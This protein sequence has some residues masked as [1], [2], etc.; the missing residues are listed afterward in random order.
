MSLIRTLQLFFESFHSFLNFPLV[1][2]DI[3]VFLQIS[4]HKNRIIDIRS[5]LPIAAMKQ[6]CL[7]CDSIT[8]SGIA[9]KTKKNCLNSNGEISNT[10]L[11]KP[12]NWH[13]KGKGKFTLVR[14]GHEALPGSFTPR[15]HCI[16]GW[17]G[18]R[19]GLDGC[20]KSPSPTGFDPWTLQPVLSRYTDWAIPAP[21]TGIVRTKIK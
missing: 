19:A 21:K 4:Q 8:T 18:P 20:G 2:T 10:R 15:T 9:W 14:T 3:A 13:S 6:S 11:W 16:G 17:M 5:Y 12:K 1:R 7:T